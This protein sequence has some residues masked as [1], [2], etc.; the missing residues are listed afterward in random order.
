MAGSVSIDICSSA[1]SPVND[2][3]DLGSPR[4]LSH[5]LAQDDIQTLFYLSVSDPL[6]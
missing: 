5:S 3:L 1:F 6:M 2:P 4:L